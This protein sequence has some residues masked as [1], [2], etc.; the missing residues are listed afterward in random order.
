MK[1]LILFST[2][3]IFIGSLCLFEIIIDFKEI[4]ISAFWHGFI[5]FWILY[6]SFKI[7]KRL[8]I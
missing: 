8:L 2:A 1:K 4:K 7:S 3:L 5:I 6:G